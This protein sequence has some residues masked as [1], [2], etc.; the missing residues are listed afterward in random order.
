MLRVVNKFI[1]F[2]F[3]N[4]SKS[5]WLNIFIAWELSPYQEAVHFQGIDLI[6]FYNTGNWITKS[7][8]WPTLPIPYLTTKISKSNLLYISNECVELDSMHFMLLAPIFSVFSMLIFSSH[9]FP[10]VLFSLCYFILFVVYF[11][12]T[13]LRIKQDLNNCSSNKVLCGK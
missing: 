9:W 7:L 1:S 6:S 11:M 10:Q 3:N 5:I 4:H 13:L 8:C 2:N 12:Q